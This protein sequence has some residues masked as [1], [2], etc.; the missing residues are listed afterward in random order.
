MI[1]GVNQISGLAGM[2]V[3]CMA[4]M[5]AAHIHTHT[6]SHTHTHTHTGDAL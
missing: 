5:Q 1:E 2:Y 3:P 4:G 6:H